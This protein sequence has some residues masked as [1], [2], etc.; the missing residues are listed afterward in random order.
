ML[1]KSLAFEDLLPTPEAART[2]APFA[3]ATN[4]E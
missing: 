3:E 4:A 2:T 1:Y